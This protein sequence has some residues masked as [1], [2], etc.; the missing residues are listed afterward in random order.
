MRA[1]SIIHFAS[2]RT[3]LCL[4]AMLVPALP[5]VADAAVFAPPPGT[6]TSTAPATP[7]VPATPAPATPTTF[8][9]PTPAPAPKA[10]TPPA[11]ATAPKATTKTSTRGTAHKPA[12]APAAPAATQPA[13]TPPVR[14]TTATSAAESASS[15]N[16][17][18]I[19]GLAAAV[20][21]LIGIAYMILRDARSVAPVSDGPTGGGTRNP[22][23]RA[24]RRRRK[25]KAARQQRKRNRVKA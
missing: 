10:S 18:L 21:L 12:A 23:G 2:L 4:S 13:A 15:G 3:A 6:P 9:T 19:I 20:A 25:A 14:T 16:T 1:S 8:A 22:A 7:A 11:P 24:Y 5:G 17:L